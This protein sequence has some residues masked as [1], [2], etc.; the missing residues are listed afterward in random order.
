MGQG[1]EGGPDGQAIGFPKTKLDFE[2]DNEG[3]LLLQNG[4]P[5]KKAI[6]SWYDVRHDCKKYIYTS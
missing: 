2:R 3:N 5:I 4:L 1:I 6:T